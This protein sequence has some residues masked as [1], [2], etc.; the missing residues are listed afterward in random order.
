MKYLLL[1]TLLILSNRF[2]FAQ[3]EINS[4]FW[5]QFGTGI[6]FMK[7]SDTDVGF[8]LLASLNYEIQNNNFSISYLRSNEF[9][10]FTHPEEYIKSIELK[11]G[12]SIDFTIRGLIFP[13]PFLLFINKDFNYSLIVKAGIS[14]NEG[15]E[16]T[17]L[18]KYELLDHSYASKV[19]TGFGFPIEIEVREEI[20]NFVGMGFSVYAN[21][22]EVKNYSGL[23]FN[24]YVGKF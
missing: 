10:M 23:N 13:F 11:Y 3:E 6:S 18:I 7:L 19:K 1:F 2:S 14:Y 22:N 17:L 9:S 24:L 20:T 15:R 21:F 4:S 5:G 16:R 8:N 12:R